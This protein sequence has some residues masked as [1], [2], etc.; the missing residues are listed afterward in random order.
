MVSAEA[1]GRRE[2]IELDGLRMP[3]I[4]RQDLIAAKRAAGRPRDKMDLEA[5][6][7][8]ESTQNAAE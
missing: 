6:A 1:W 8:A 2:E 4:S 5:L 3:F 7:M